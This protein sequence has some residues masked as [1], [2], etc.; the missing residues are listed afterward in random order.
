M[1]F[2][3]LST[4]FW[5]APSS[6]MNTFEIHEFG[7]QVQELFC[8]YGIMF[9]VLASMFLKPL[10]YWSCKSL[11]IFGLYMIFITVFIGFDLEA[12][13][14]LLNVFLMVLFYKT[15]VE[16]ITVK[17]IKTYLIWFFW[18]AVANLILCFYQQFNI[19][20]IFGH[21]QKD[22]LSLSM[23]ARWE[24]VVGFMKL[25]ANLGVLAAILGPALF[26]VHPVLVVILI[27]LLVYGN[28]SA[29]VGAFVVTILFLLWYRLK[30]WIFALMCLGMLAG[31]SF[32][33]VKYDMP[34][35]QFAARLPI[36]HQTYSKTLKISP[37]LG[38]GAGS[39]MKWAPQQKQETVPDKKIWIWAHNEYIQLFYEAGVAGL[40][41]ILIFLG[42]RCKDFSKHSKD[43]ELQVLFSG[44]L[45]V[46][47]VS[48]FHFPFH[49][50]KFAA[51]CTFVFALFH[52]KIMELEQNE[53]NMDSVPLSVI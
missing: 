32:Y 34:G 13:R 24:W 52:A 41:I 21:I 9:V 36:W 46:M 4:M 40:V 50:G 3:V 7:Y 45:A 25:R 27:P 30:K 23:S 28:S 29:A 31:G 14:V 10:R 2:V 47:M 38:F 1:I 11:P 6:Q 12:R 42:Y 17:K 18:I 48:F 49:V 26:L 53:K 5:R 15:V 39:Y 44:I 19:D 37:Y 51:L 16:H 22:V 8:R 20:P 43:R 35:G 33:I